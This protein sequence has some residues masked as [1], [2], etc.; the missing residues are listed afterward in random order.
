[1]HYRAITTI[2]VKSRVEFKTLASYQVLKNPFFSD[3]RKGIV[4]KNVQYLYRSKDFHDS[5][6][7]KNNKLM[8]DQIAP[9]QRIFAKI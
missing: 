1:M 8:Y 9:S 3:F 2:D 4:E 5:G 6:R 7:P